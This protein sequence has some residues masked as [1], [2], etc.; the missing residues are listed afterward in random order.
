MGVQRDGFKGGQLQWKNCLTVG[1][2]TL[3]NGNRAAASLHTS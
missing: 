3:F 2:R 1:K